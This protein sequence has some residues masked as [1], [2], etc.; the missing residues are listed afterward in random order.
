MCSAHIM[1]VRVV[2]F[3][4]SSLISFLTFIFCWPF[5]R[6]TSYLCPPPPPHTHTSPLT[7]VSSSTFSGK[8][9]KRELDGK[10][11]EK[12]LYMSFCFFLSFPP[13]PHS[14][15]FIFVVEIIR[16]IFNLG[17]WGWRVREGK[18]VRKD[19]WVGRKEQ[20]ENTSIRLVPGFGCVRRYRHTQNTIDSSC[21]RDSEYEWLTFTI[22]RIKYSPSHRYSKL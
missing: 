19:E 17:N 20:T 2:T 22:S 4:S 10:F 11:W 1:C 16:C 5:R 13:F 18:L 6:Q 7:H 8:K 14:F 3:S 9:K 12:L 15:R 21:L